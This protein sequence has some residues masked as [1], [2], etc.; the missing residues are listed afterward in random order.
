MD[1]ISMDLKTEDNACHVKNNNG[2]YF[3]VRSEKATPTKKLK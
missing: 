1:L 3:Q 2:Y